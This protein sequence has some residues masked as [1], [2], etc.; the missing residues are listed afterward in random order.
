M[1]NRFAVS[2]LL[3]LAVWM[4]PLASCVPDEPEPPQQNDEPAAND[5]ASESPFDT[6]FTRPQPGAPDTA[7]ED[8]IVELVESTPD[9]ASILAAFYTFSRQRVAD[10]FIDAHER[11][12]S[13]YVVL[14][15][16]N[17]FS[18]GSPWTA[19]QMLDDGLDGNLTIC[20]RDESDGGCMGDNIH[21]NK[22]MTFSELE[23]GSEHVVLQTSANL[24]N[25]QLEQYNNMVISHDDEALYESFRSYWNQLQRDETNLDYNQHFTGDNNTRAYF[26]PHSSG[27]PVL[28]VLNRI[29]CAAETDVY[30]AVAFFTNARASVAERLRSLDTDGCNIH[31]V[32]RERPEVFSPGDK[33][34]DELRTGNVDLGIFHE[35]EDVQLHSKYLAVDGSYGGDDDTRLVWTG[36]HNYTHYALRNNDE[37]LLKIRDDAVFDDYL[38]DWQYIRDQ[39]YTLEP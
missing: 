34:I 19:V 27:D 24:T 21:H 36:S 15:N 35:D 2:T 31:V 29:D 37:V 33:I 17:R 12:V 6:A 23:D 4:V 18:D 5:D 28:D 32:L 10:A 20:N 25:D 13:V 11:G 1:N 22:F 14:G 9:D 30:V 8:R 26:F 7:I 16:T 3:V 38:D 39:A